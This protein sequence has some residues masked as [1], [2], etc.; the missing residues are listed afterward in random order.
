[1]ELPSRLCNIPWPA[2]HQEY[3]NYLNN[4][5]KKTGETWMGQ[6]GWD[7]KDGTEGWV[8]VNRLTSA[9][10]TASQE[11]GPLPPEKVFLAL[12]LMLFFTANCFSIYVGNFVINIFC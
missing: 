9:A 4:E 12:N 5:M 11:V 7:R 2:K 10:V 1:M 8:L 3:Y 6:K